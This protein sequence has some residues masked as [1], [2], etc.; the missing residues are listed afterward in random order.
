MLRPGVRRYCAG[1]LV[2]LALP[3]AC[4]PRQHERVDKVLRVA[5]ETRCGALDPRYSVDAVSSRIGDLIFSRLVRV[6]ESLDVLPDLAERW[7][8]EDG[9]RLYRFHLR[10]GVRF[11]DG[12]ELDASD[13]VFTFKSLLDPNNASPKR[14]T[15]SFL[16]SVEAT[17][18][19]T[20]VFRLREPN[21]PFLSNV[22]LGI[23]PSEAAS[24]PSKAG[25]MPVGSGPFQ[26]VGNDDGSLVELRAFDGYFGGRPPLDGIVFR[27]ISEPSMRVLEL[28]KGTI[29]FLQNDLIPEFIPAL[30]Q[31]PNLKVMSAPGI[32]CSYLG[33]NLRDPA[34]RN[35]RV[36]KAIGHAIDREAIQALLLRETATL[37]DTIL[38]PSV[39]GA[40]PE[41][42][43]PAY[44]PPEARR[45]LEEAGFPDPDGDGP[46]PRLSLVYKTSTDKLR[47]RIAEILRRNLGDVGIRVQIQS[48]EFGTLFNDIKTGNFQLYSLTWVGLA[49]PDGLYN[50]FHSSAIPP[51]GAN[52]VFYSNPLVDR[53][54]EQG[55]VELD[56]GRRRALYAQVDRI[57]AE[58][59]PLLPLW[60]TNNVAAMRSDVEGFELSPTGSFAS[61]ARVWFAPPAAPSDPS[62]ASR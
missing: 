43:A 1:A 20:V 30:R 3:L 55:R 12:S 17:D 39:S 44:D 16:E 2:A 58:D 53:L 5:L 56:E 54:L 21:A 26:V 8:V 36:R 13:V 33:M 40:A 19:R 4:G 23:L 28:E 32:N 25:P 59:L 34:L 18:S 46:E 10:P 51:Q 29:D 22:L 37:A 42:R 49:E 9:G 24:D 27:T 7:D 60:Y 11:Q 6:D 50:I 45:L 31:D 61:M 41:V 48:Y 52:R 35:A 62:A 14:A 47:L 57:L 38:A 15:F